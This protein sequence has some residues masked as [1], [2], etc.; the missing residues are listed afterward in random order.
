[1]HLHLS[2]STDNPQL[3]S[4]MPTDN[5]PNIKVSNIIVAL[6]AVAATLCIAC[7]CMYASNV[8]LIM[9]RD[10]YFLI[11]TAIAGVVLIKVKLQRQ[12]IR[13]RCP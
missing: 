4:T 12:K 1:M 6:V 10:Y 5:F 11:F 3:D 9:N 13:N 8:I 7:T 2:G